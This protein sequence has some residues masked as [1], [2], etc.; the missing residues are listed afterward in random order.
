MRKEYPCDGEFGA[1][2]FADSHGNVAGSCR[3][4]CGVGV[5]EEDVN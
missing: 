1:C 4:N 2:P 3:D 5:E